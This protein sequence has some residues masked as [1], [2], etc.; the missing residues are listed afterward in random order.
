MIV[1]HAP[2]ARVTHGEQGLSSI[3]HDPEVDLVVVVL[4][5]QAALQVRELR[6]YRL[7]LGKSN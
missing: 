1:R 4:P 7:K 3:L 2:A 5:V 6:V